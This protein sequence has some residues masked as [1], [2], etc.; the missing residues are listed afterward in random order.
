MRH[1]STTAITALLI[2]IA[3]SVVI[4]ALFATAIADERNNRPA[5]KAAA[6]ARCALTVFEDASARFETSDLERDR[7]LRRLTGKGLR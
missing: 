1:A 5:L 4:V 3:N 2:G 6:E 7:C